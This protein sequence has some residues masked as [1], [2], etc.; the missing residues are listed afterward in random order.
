MTVTFTLISLTRYID[1]PTREIEETLTPGSPESMRHRLL[2]GNPI[3][4][5]LIFKF[6]KIQF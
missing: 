6:L 4:T 1:S 2:S 3:Y 5:G